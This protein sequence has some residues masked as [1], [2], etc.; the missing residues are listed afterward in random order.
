LPVFVSV[1]S[2]VSW[3]FAVSL[4]PIWHATTFPP[5]FVIGA[6]H[7]GVSAVLTL[8]A[9]MRKF[10][11]WEKHLRPEHF[12]AIGRLLIAVASSW[13][14][15]FMLDVLFAIYSNEPGDLA[16]MQIRLLEYPWGLLFWLIVFTSYIIP[17]PLWL[18]ASNRRNITLMFWSSI[19][20]NIGMWSER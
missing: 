10:F 20:V 13:L 6:V 11:G 8:M 3:D 12:D 1:H 14:Y 5:Y 4:V 18:K 2:I 7:S 15:F 17:I 16:V 9:I 19:L